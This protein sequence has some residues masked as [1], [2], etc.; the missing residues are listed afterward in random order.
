M[1]IVKPSTALINLP[2]LIK[3]VKKSTFEF[4]KN[5]LALY[6]VNGERRLPNSI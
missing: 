1:K 2:G 5:S 6:C 3:D 4:F